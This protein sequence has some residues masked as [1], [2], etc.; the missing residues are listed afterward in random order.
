MRAGL[1]H[2]KKL[3]IK[4]EPSW[5]FFIMFCALEGLHI[6]AFRTV[7]NPACEKKLEKKSVKNV[8]GIK[9]FK[10]TLYSHIRSWQSK[11]A[12]LA[13]DTCLSVV[14]RSVLALLLYLLPS[15]FI[16]DTCCITCYYPCLLSVL[17]HPLLFVFVGTCS[18]AFRLPCLSPVLA[19]LPSAFL[20]YLQYLCHYLMPT[21]YCLLS[22]FSLLFSAFLAFVGTCS[23]TFC[24]PCLSSVLSPLPYAFLVTVY[25]Q[26]FLYY[27]LPSLFVFSI[28]LIYM[29]RTCAV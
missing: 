28:R 17:A 13:S 27:F 1:I 10:Y 25:F 14:Q 5:Q 3:L 9:P 15:L 23:I 16:V 11:I 4:D 20:V 2:S 12:N 22:A 26:Y 7:I 24:L 29:K 21:C 19:L 18:I 6:R 8:K